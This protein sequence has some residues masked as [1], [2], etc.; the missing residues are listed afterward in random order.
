MSRVL[1][2]RATDTRHVA[3]AAFFE[4]GADLGQLIRN[5]RYIL[6]GDLLKLP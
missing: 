1:H 4:V 3:A 6:P 5:G 2:G